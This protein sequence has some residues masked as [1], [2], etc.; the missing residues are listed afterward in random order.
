MDKEKVNG[1]LKFWPQILFVMAV[2]SGYAILCQT[3]TTHSLKINENEANDAI[4]NERIQKRELIDAMRDEQFSY[5]SEKLDDLKVELRYA[6]EQ[7]K[8]MNE[9]I[10]RKLDER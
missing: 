6:M 3:V 4:Q 2:V 7:Q 5:L 10:M 1:I 8:L 9:Q